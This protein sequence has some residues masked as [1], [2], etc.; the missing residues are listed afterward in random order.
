MTV[1]SATEFD[2]QA[3]KRAYEEWDI[4]ALLDLYAD[5]VELVQT[6]RDSPASAPRE[7]GVRLPRAWPAPS[8]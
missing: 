8:S 5:D 2:V 7:D 4:E 1:E 3:F 6:D